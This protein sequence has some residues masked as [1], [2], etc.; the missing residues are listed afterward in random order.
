MAQDEREPVNVDSL[1]GRLDEHLDLM[2]RSTVCFLLCGFGSPEFDSHAE[3]LQHV[4]GG[5]HARTTGEDGVVLDAA[6]HAQVAVQTHDTLRARPGHVVVSVGAARFRLSRQYATDVNEVSLH[7]PRKLLRRGC[8][9]C[10]D[11]PVEFAANLADLLGTVLPASAGERDGVVEVLRAEEVL[12]S[13]VSAAVLGRDLFD[14]LDEGVERVEG[15]AVVDDVVHGR[16][17]LCLNHSG[18]PACCQTDSPVYDTTQKPLFFSL[19][20]WFP[21]PQPRN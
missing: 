9:G 8:L 3:S 19:K 5:E 2:N 13:Q 16:L 20:R 10:L 12:A 18:R 21:V 4:H 6:A 15:V 17:L 7:V 11:E 1:I 14:V